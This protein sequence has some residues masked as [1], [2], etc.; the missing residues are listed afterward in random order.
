MDNVSTCAADVVPTVVPVKVKVV[1]LAAAEV[2]W[3]VPVKVTVCVPIP[4]TN[5]RYPVA[6]PVVVGLKLALAVQLAPADKLA[7]QLFGAVK[8]PLIVTLRLTGWLPVLVNV[9][10]CAVEEDP[11]CVAEP[12]SRDGVTVDTAVNKPVPFRL[13]VVEPTALGNVKVPVLLF[14]TVGV[15]VT[16]YVQ[17]APPANEALQVVALRA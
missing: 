2:C 3:P 7:G 4:V 15:N 6:V 8:A 12:K 9:T 17:L 11:T 14:I 16:L 1:G 5:C 13:T 10:P